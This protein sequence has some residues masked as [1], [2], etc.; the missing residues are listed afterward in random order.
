MTRFLLDQLRTLPLHKKESFRFHYR[1]RDQ[2][3]YQGLTKE[4]NNTPR[5]TSQDRTS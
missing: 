1:D 5:S 3:L 2:N 4:F